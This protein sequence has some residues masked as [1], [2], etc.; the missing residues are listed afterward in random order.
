MKHSTILKISVYSVVVGIQIYHEGGRPLRTTTLQPL[1]SHSLK[2][3]PHVT[4]VT[5]N[6]LIFPEGIRHMAAWKLMESPCDSLNEH[7]FCTVQRTLLLQEISDR[8]L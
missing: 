7:L 5:Q 6:D 4:S 3:A 1:V 2:R 8:Y